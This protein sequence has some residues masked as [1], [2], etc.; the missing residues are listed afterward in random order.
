MAGEQTN[1]TLAVSAETALRDRLRLARIAA[2]LEQKDLAQAIGIGLRTYERIESGARP[3]RRGE[4]IA[5]AQVTG[6][7]VSFF[8][9]SPDADGAEVLTGGASPVNDEAKQEPAAALTGARGDRLETKG[10]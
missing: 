6:Q 9:A 2:G 1:L 7:E 3:L 4:L 10:A 8:G 5:I